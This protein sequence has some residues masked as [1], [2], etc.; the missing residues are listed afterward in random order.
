MIS[1]AWTQKRVQPEARQSTTL[2]PCILD[3]ALPNPLG[4]SPEEALLTLPVGTESMLDH[5]AHPLM[6]FGA[7]EVW[8]VASGSSGPEYEDR[9]Q[10][11]TCCPI[12]IMRPEEFAQTV[13]R[14]ETSDYLLM[15]EPRIWPEQGYDFDEFVQ[16]SRWYRGATHAIAIGEDLHQTRERVAYDSSGRVRG[17]DRLYRVMSWPEA[18]SSVFCSIVPAKALAHVDF[19]SLG[20]VRAKLARLG[21][22]TQDVPVATDV[23]HLTD[24]G[25]I[26]AA[27]ERII[28]QAS[29]GPVR[30]GFSM[31]SPRVL[32]SRRSQVHPSARF[33]G[34]VIVQHNATVE[35]GA[36]VFG[37]AIIGAGALVERG[38]IVA[39][40]VLRADS[41]VS[42]RC[43]ICHRVVADGRVRRS[44]SQPPGVHLSGGAA[45]PSLPLQDR[46]VRKSVF[47]ADVVRHRLSLAAKRLI[48]VTLTVVGLILLSPL[49]I[50]VAVLIKLTSPGPVFFIHRR[51]RKGGRE[52]PCMKFRTMAAD[53]HRQQR[54]LYQKNEVD[55]PQFKL[56]DD[57]RV[58]RLGVLLR[59][60]NI[61][62]LPQL[63][64]VLLGHMSL[65]GPRPS[66]FRENQVCVPWRRARLSVR[67]GITGLWQVCRD[68]RAEADFYQWIFYDLAYV[69]NMSVWVDIKILFF[70]VITKGGSWPV[71]LP[72]LIPSDRRHS[73]D[74]EA[75][76][77]AKARAP[78]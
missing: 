1:T 52:F 46:R 29:H 32:V 44:A 47:R 72:W 35:E 66:P 68:R 13:T 57:P 27:S 38:A 19:A 49:L 23:V 67:P 45:L 51:E 65:V 18:T 74:F 63:F 17:V 6:E 55:G 15:V 33:V 58:T 9:I 31:R 34:P 53:A 5:L 10:R 24:E 64:N 75:T 48:D 11:C 71:P 22:C 56:K 41:V 42:A 7:S 61:D 30:A 2:I 60:T 26:L 69:R 50:S 76:D 12:R 4:A 28:R 36:I 20:E 37:P 62:E 40:S 54:K 73:M 3:R 16:H 78:R 70:T 59:K 8:I 14:C 77:P 39:H 21:V 43:T 25:A